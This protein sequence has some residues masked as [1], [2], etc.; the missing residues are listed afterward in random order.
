M[1]CKGYNSNFVG[2]REEKKNWHVILLCSIKQS[3]N[4]VLLI[5]LTTYLTQIKTQFNKK[6]NLNPHAYVLYNVY[7]FIIRH[8]MHVHCRIHEHGQYV[9]T[10]WYILSIY[11]VHILKYILRIV[12]S[13]QPYIPLLYY[14]ESHLTSNLSKKSH[15]TSQIPPLEKIMTG[16]CGQIE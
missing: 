8:Y 6:T 4:F 16:Y 15:L 13:W 14:K 12:P 9:S 5:C 10:I 7:N 3:Y 11:T 2:K 1:I